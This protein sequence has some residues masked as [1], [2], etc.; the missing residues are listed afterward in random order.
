MERMKLCEDGSNETYLR[1]SNQA[2]RVRK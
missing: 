1:V 2:A